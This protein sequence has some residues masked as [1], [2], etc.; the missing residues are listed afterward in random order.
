M[1]RSDYEKVECIGQ[2]SFGTVWK[3]RNKKTGRTVAIKILDLEKSE[4]EIEDVQK[5]IS[6]LSSLSSKNVT[7]YYESFVDGNYLWIIMEYLGG[8]SVRDIIVSLGEKGLDEHYV[9]IILREV[10]QGLQYMHKLGKIHRD[11]KSANILLADDGKVKLADFGVVGQL[12]DT[13]NKRTT[14]VGTPYWMAPEVILGYPH[15]YLADI[16]SLGITAIEM[17]KGRPPLSHLPA[18]KVLM[19][20]PK[21]QPPILEGNY[22]DELKEFVDLCL[23]RESSDRPSAKL[24]LESAFIRKAKP[25]SHLTELLKKLKKPAAKQAKPTADSDGSDDGSGG[26]DDDWDFDDTNFGTIVPNRGGRNKPPVG[27]SVSPAV[28]A[29]MKED[30][31]GESSDF[32]G[33]GGF[34]GGTI[35]MARKDQHNAD[36]SLDSP[37]PASPQRPES[38]AGPAYI[39]AHP[40]PLRTRK[41]FDDLKNHASK[42]VQRAGRLILTEL[43]RINDAKCE[44][45]DQVD[46]LEAELSKVQAELA[47]LKQKLQRK[48]EQRKRE[49]LEND[50]HGNRKRSKSSKPKKDRKKKEGR[51][52]KSD[53]SKGDRSK[54]RKE[55]RRSD[56]S[57]R[58]HSKNDSRASEK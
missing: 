31:D 28:P 15:D 11:I 5:E 39:A 9:A 33:V 55:D 2:G 21:K 27:P 24:L 34:D 40:L 44:K 43:E 22:S 46:Q 48:K 7:K 54:S 53:R 26:D 41:L 23:Q 49:K 29:E 32:D 20:I 58:G 52:S 38:P 45:R 14:V 42:K 57:R 1:G 25:T 10:L 3:G 30:D 56:R 19:Q 13:V 8:G 36:L 50:D 12:T 37:P 18:L 35:K 47:A 51:S 4:E 16:W 6:A 17:A